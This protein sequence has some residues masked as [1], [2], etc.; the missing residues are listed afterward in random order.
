[1]LCHNS[2]KR[3]HTRKI[4]LPKRKCIKNL[5][6]NIIQKVEITQ[7]YWKT[8]W[9]FQQF[10][11]RRKLHT[12]MIEYVSLPWTRPHFSHIQR[13][14]SFDFDNEMIQMVR[15]QE[16]N[17]W[18]SAMYGC[19]AKLKGYFFNNIL[20]EERQC[21]PS[22]VISE[23]AGCS[24][25]KTSCN[26]LIKVVFNPSNAFSF[27]FMSLWHMTFLH[28]VCTSLLKRVQI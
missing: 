28:H 18:R 4:F 7:R 5:T 19:G 22:C 13:S 15:I 10:I 16:W 20:I 21:P 12:R 11:L 23:T 17:H 2:P 26:D 9:I 25:F 3:S 14:H 27:Y 1:M 8:E 6:C 24:Y